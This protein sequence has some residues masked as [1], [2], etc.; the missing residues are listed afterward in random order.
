MMTT[1]VSAL[2]TLDVLR[3]LM[4]GYAG[5]MIPKAGE[6]FSSGIPTEE[7]EIDYS[8]SDQDTKDGIAKAMAAFRAEL[9]KQNP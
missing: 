9:K 3:P 1:A 5:V 6:L 4:R 2:G 7:I 8:V